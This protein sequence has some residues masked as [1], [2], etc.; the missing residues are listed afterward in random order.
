MTA[1]GDGLH[2]WRSQ[3]SAQAIRL[4]ERK[5]FPALATKAVDPTGARK[6]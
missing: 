2:A 1:A 4:I 6:I 3:A 5:L